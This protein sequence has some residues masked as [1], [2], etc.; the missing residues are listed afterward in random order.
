ML[1]DK[2]GKEKMAAVYAM[3]TTVTSVYRRI[4]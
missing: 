4:M 2:S 3:F 1:D